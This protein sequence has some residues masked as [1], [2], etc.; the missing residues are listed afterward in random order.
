MG[1]GSCLKTCNPYLRPN[2]AYYDRSNHCMTKKDSIKQAPKKFD[3]RNLLL[4]GVGLLVGLILVEVGLRI[5]Y[6]S[7]Q[8]ALIAGMQSN[9]FIAKNGY[10]TVWHHVNNT[11][12]IQNPC[13]EGDYVTNQYGMKD[14][15]V[16][17][18]TRKIALI[19]DSY[20]EGFGVPNTATMSYYLDSM[21]GGQ[22]DALNF[23]CSGGFSNVQ[24]LSLYENFASGFAPEVVFLFFL[25]YNDFF[26]NLD[27]KQAG[28][29]N[30]EGE[31]TY[32]RAKSFE[33]MVE[34]VAH[35]SNPVAYDNSISGLYTAQ[36]VLKGVKVLGAMSAGAVGG[37]TDY[38]NALAEVYAPNQN[39]AVD[40]GREIFS[41]CLERFKMLCNRDSAELVLVQ[42]P[43]PFQTDPDWL[44]KAGAEI[45]QTLDPELPNRQIAAICSELNVRYLDMYPLAKD[46][47]ATRD[48]EF[49]YIYNA[50]DRHFNPEGNQ[51]TAQVLMSYLTDSLPGLTQ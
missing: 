12:S 11:T 51:F 37:R 6:T 16:A 20:V 33:A 13:F 47:I 49:P 45:G 46:Y 10:W 25:N 18:D 4:L 26:D 24:E 14:G 1:S 21:L 36:A 31:F 22:F 42:L 8:T 23:G 44:Q 38:S 29:I 30:D 15:P 35:R 48:L 28:L 27:S 41:K 43:D 34:Y 50:C 2:P 7:N 9:S 32:A 3:W 17:A 5:L 39:P 40:E 19:G